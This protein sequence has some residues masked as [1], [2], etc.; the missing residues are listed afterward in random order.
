MTLCVISFLVID[1]IINRI[2]INENTKRL[3]VAVFSYRL[4][5]SYNFGAARDTEVPH[6]NLSAEPA[7]PFMKI[8][9]RILIVPLIRVNKYV[10][11]SWFI[12]LD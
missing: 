1:N 9:H 5:T 2:E 10:S 11:A 12:P 4:F 7:A 3:T 6:K 8:T